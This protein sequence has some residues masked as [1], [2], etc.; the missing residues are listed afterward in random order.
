MISHHF[1]G[2]NFN[3]QESANALFDEYAIIHAPNVFF[4]MTRNLYRFRIWSTARTGD[5]IA[6]NYQVGVNTSDP[7]LVLYHRWDQPPTTLMNEIVADIDLSFTNTNGLAM[8]TL[9]TVSSF[10]TWYALSSASK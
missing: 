5:E 2:A 4:E 9:P 6:F 8:G 1:L 10:M 7:T 3:D